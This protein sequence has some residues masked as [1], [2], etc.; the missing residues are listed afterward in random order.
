MN[1]TIPDDDSEP[2]AEETSNDLNNEEAAGILVKHM[3]K[4]KTQW[5]VIHKQAVIHQL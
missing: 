2:P 1:I 4:L 3:G 5:Q